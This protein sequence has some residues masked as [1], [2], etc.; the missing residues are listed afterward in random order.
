MTVTH[1]WKTEDTQLTLQRG[2]FRF[3]E[4]VANHL[5]LRC[6]G[7]C[8]VWIEVFDRN[9][10]QQVIKFLR[11]QNIRTKKHTRTK[12]KMKYRIH[13]PFEDWLV[14]DQGF[15]GVVI[16]LRG[17]FEKQ[18]Y[19]QEK[20][21]EDGLVFREGYRVG[22]STLWCQIEPF[23]DIVG[24]W[25]GS[26]GTVLRG[27]QRNCLLGWEYTLEIHKGRQVIYEYVDSKTTLRDL[28]N[29]EIVTHV[30]FHQMP[31]QTKRRK[32]K[33]RYKPMRNGELF[34]R[35]SGKNIQHRKCGELLE[36]QDL[37]GTRLRGWNV[38]GYAGLITHVPYLRNSGI[39]TAVQATSDL[40]ELYKGIREKIQRKMGIEII[41]VPNI[42]GRMNK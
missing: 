5:P 19:I 30:I 26:V 28:S 41:L 13:H 3:D 4:S 18:K 10:L 8:L 7:R 24:L 37:Y 23:Q 20:H 14:Q 15:Q 38:E 32:N 21:G 34:L 36:V 42:I 17:D 16:R 12:R 27:E 40:L 35:K 31:S 9:E 33:E 22:V 25:T 2:F 39:S 6:G 29:K 11:K 1:T